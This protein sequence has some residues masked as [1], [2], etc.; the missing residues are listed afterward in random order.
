MGAHLTDFVDQT[1]GVSLNTE[2]DD[3]IDAEY[4]GINTVQEVH[5]KIN[6]HMLPSPGK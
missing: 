6:E 4:N 5:V 1:Q 2:R 3:R